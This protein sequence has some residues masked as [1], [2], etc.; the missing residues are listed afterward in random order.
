MTLKKI[1]KILLAG[2]GVL[3]LVLVLTFLF[4]LGPTVKLVAQS[5]GTKALGTPL[6]IDRL[7]INPRKGTIHLTDFAIANPDTFGK[8]NAVSL[9]SLNVAIDISSIFSQT[10]VVHQVSINSP[11]FIYEQSSASD[12]MNEFIQSIQE[13]AGF[14]PSA[15]PLPKTPKEQEKRRK[16]AEK[17]A[18]KNKGKEPKVVV[19]ESL[20]IN[21]VSFHLANTD[22][23][24]LDFG[25]G[26][27]QL[28]VSMTN[29][30]VKL[31]HFYVSNPGRLETPNLFSLEQFEL[32]LDPDA[33]YS[34]NVKVH[35]INIRKPH[36]FVEHNPETD[37]LGEFLKIAT[38]LMAKFPT[39]APQN[40]A[41]NETIAVAEP[42]EPTAPATQVTLGPL[43]IEDVQIHLVNVGDPELSVQLG[44][45]QLAVAMEK[46]RV[47]LDHLFVTNPKRLDSPNLFSLEAVRVDFD[48]DSLNTATPVLKDI[49]VRK[50][51]VF[52]ELNNEANTVDEL[53]KIANGFIDRIPTCIL[54][55][56]LKAPLAPK[57]EMAGVVGPPAPA[58]PPVELHNLLVDDIQIKLLDTTATQGVPTEPRMLAGIGEISIKLVDGHL[59][60]KGITI[61]N[62]EGFLGTNLFHLAGIDISIQP[63][64][65]FS[66][67]VIID[68]VLIDSPEVHL[69][70]TEES[71]NVVA[72]QTQL[73]QFALSANTVVEGKEVPNPEPT[74]PEEI[75]DP[76]PLSEQ[77]VMLHQ[78]VIT[79]LAVSLKLPVAIT[80]ATAGVFG[81][82]VGKL[83]PM[84]KISFHKLNPLSEGAKEEAVD[85]NAPLTL[86]AFQ[87][88]S[89]EPLKGLLQLNGLRIS[90]PPDFSRRDLINIEQFR[91]DLQPDTLQA[92]TLVIEDILVSCPRLRYE[93]QIRSDNIKALQKEIEKATVRRKD[94]LEKGEGIE[95]TEMADTNLED[96]K[97]KV[98][99]ER[100]VVDGCIVYAKLSA[101]PSIP[102]PLPLPELNDIGKEKGGATAAE[103]SMQ[104][105]DTFYEEII[106]AIGNTTG[107]AGDALKGVGSFGKDAFG[108]V[109]GGV[110]D[111]VG[112]VTQGASS[113]VKESVEKSE[114]RR[115]KRCSR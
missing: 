8:S 15:P 50:P 100:V 101:L 35:A 45:D 9:A 104:I 38:V 69:E 114:S 34:S 31:D 77:P 113:V 25:M 30:T 48:S 11:H 6:T 86:I 106:N 92:D 28:S 2:I 16:K 40:S 5:I 37:T 99:I 70:Q 97:Q 24:Q 14:D 79:N 20:E 10:V 95:K 29:G 105:F 57:S 13:F 7:S 39:N 64:S 49:Q 72:L 58:A 42:N 18:R 68:N 51:Y 71:G 88:L 90:N 22:D 59:H 82:T 102:I 115:K 80:N 112:A 54:P 32:L 76:I 74:E 12:N 23:E 62:A 89:L 1:L 41:T 36:A 4:W 83:N 53:M 47:D 55:D 21:D 75:S 81:G 98:I 87:Q 78:L 73:M 43:T 93:R 66:D 65:L 111:G 107:F 44:F 27:G 108:T 26:F 110:V 61:P 94:A 84:G 85:P 52:L 96:D 103:A 67:Q 60:V 46:G 109:T 63:D 19:V 17:K 56:V 91:I 3:L 33:I